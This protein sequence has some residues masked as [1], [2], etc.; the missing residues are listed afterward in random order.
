IGCLLLL[1]MFWWHYGR[2]KMT[3]ERL[4]GASLVNGEDLKALVNAREDASPYVIAYVPMRAKSENLHTLIA[5][6]QGTGKS[7]QFFALMKQVRARGK[8]AIVYD[9]SGEF[10]QAFFRPGKDILM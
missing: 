6:A 5:G 8:R 1:S 4:R 9:P 2:G 10:T 3:D 7:Q